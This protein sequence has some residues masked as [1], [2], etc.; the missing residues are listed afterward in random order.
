MT[1]ACVSIVVRMQLT[2]EAK[3]KD[4]KTRFFFIL[5]HRKGSSGSSDGC[6]MSTVLPSSASLISSESDIFSTCKS[7]ATL[8]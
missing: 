3:T 5:G 1:L 8:S 4:S 6:G 7:P 2:K